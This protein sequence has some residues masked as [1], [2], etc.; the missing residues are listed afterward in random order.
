M[1]FIKSARIRV[2]YTLQHLNPIPAVP[3]VLSCGRSRA[4]DGSR[5]ACSPPPPLHAPYLSGQMREAHRRVP[6]PLPPIF[7]YCSFQ[8]LRRIFLAASRPRSRVQKLIW[9]SDDDYFLLLPFFDRT[10]RSRDIDC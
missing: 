8:R 2:N 5:V 7:N 9:G 1:H 6:P 10:P 4:P 3:L